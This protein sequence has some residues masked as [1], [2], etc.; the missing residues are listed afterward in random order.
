MLIAR[1]ARTQDRHIAP[2]TIG[3]FLRE[4]AMKPIAGLPHTFDPARTP[5][6]AMRTGN[7]PHLPTAIRA[8]PLTEKQRRSTTSHYGCLL[9]E[10]VRR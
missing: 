5:A 6:C 9:F 1:R 2:E 4:A 8:F 10:A 7:C 3:R